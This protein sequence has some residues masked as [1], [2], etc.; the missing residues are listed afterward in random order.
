MTGGNMVIDITNPFS[1]ILQ[2][3]TVKVTWNHDKGHQTGSDKTLILDKVNLGAGLMWDGNELGPDANIIPSVTATIPA[4]S[5]SSLTFIFHQIFD[6]WD[7]TESVQFFFAN[8]GCESVQPKQT[9][10]E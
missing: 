6:R 10:H 3:S 2:I 4:N 8:P 9:I 5:T 1:S 7:N